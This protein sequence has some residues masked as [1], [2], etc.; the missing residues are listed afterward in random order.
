MILL[1][2]FDMRNLLLIA[3]ITD[4]VNLDPRLKAFEERKTKN[5]M[6]GEVV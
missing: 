6:L 1:F 5:G 2:V 4:V 3:P